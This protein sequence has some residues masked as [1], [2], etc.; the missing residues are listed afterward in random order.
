MAVSESF[1]KKTECFFFFFVLGGSRKGLKNYCDPLMLTDC[2]N[3]LVWKR[4]YYTIFPSWKQRKTVFPSLH[5]SWFGGHAP[6][7]WAIHSQVSPGRI[8]C[9]LYFLP[10]VVLWKNGARRHSHRKKITESSFK[11]E[12]RN[13]EVISK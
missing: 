3:N 8:L 1:N 11:R 7:V 5:W 9:L 10:S 4:I 12:R 13:T 6:K 2:T